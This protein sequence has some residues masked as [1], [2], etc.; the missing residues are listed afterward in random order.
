MSLEQMTSFFQVLINQ[1]VSAE[2]HQ[3][4]SSS[5]AA[6][7]QEAAKQPTKDMI[8]IA[9]TLRSQ[10]ANLSH[11]ILDSLFTKSVNFGG[12]QQLLNDVAAE[13]VVE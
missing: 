12:V 2:T 7:A 10:L 6:A 9:R 5:G 1:I 8:T 11:I 13:I 4:D 3:E